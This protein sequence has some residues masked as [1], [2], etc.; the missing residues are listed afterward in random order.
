MRPCQNAGARGRPACSVAPRLSRQRIARSYYLCAN[1][2]SRGAENGTLDRAK[3]RLGGPNDANRPSSKHQRK[4]RPSAK[5][6]TAGGD[7]LAAVGVR[8]TQTVA[9]L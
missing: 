8:R 7:E 4:G 5:V 1:A 2:G 6:R 9:A 3:R